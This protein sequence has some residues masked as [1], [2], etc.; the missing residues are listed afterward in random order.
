MTMIRF[1][2]PRR[3][4][5]TLSIYNVRGER[6]KTLV[7]EVMEPGS[8]VVYWDGKNEEGE[9]MGSGV[10]FYRLVADGFVKS[11]KMILIR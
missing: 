6:V 4:R 9:P 1:D 2:I 8:K 5:V 11:K 7:N 3:C 10:Y